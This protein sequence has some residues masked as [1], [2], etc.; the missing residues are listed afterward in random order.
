MHFV[1]RGLW[2]SVA[3]SGMGRPELHLIPAYIVGGHPHI[4]GSG[5][6]SRVV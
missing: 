1:I 6:T 2:H 5:T 3:S 4:S